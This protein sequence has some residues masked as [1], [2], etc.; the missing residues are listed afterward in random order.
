[1]PFAIT[2]AMTSAAT[3]STEAA[4][5]IHNQRGALGRPGAGSGGG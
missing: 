5:T 3:S 4:A 1:V 2:S